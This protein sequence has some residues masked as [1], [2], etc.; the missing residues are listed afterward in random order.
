MWQG[1]LSLRN[2]ILHL[3]SELDSFWQDYVLQW[4]S[5]HI[6][7]GA[8]LEAARFFMRLASNMSHDLLDLKRVEVGPQEVGQDVYPGPGPLEPPSVI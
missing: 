4:S 5:L 8:S 1:I 7:S 6:D 2:E 3:G